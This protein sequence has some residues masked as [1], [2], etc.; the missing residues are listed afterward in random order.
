[1]LKHLNLII[2]LIVLYSTSLFASP[3]WFDEIP[4]QQGF[5]IGVGIGDNI[6]EAKQ[7]A[8]ADIGNTLYSNVSSS[9]AN[10]VSVQNENIKTEF[11]SNKLVSSENVLLPTVSWQKLEND[12]DIYYAMAKVSIAE[13]VS[14]Y[15]KNLTLKLSE[16]NNLL[17]EKKLSLAEYLQLVASDKTLQIAAQRAASITHLSEKAK[18]SFSQIMYL[19]NKKNQ[20]IGSVCFNVEKSHDRLADKIY[21]PAIE[22]AVQA[23]KFE[24]NNEASCIPIRFRSKTEK[25]RKEGKTI[26]DVT[27]Q[28]TI[29]SPS[30]TSNIIKFKGQSN[31]SYKSA[32]FDATDQFGNYFQTSGGLLNSLLQTSEKTI[33]IDS[34]E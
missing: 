10:K 9:I 15:E 28:L 21:L 23:D 2:Y 7:A 4:Q 18:V 20:F 6:A 13:L 3:K 14:L 32:M 26:A 16:F 33:V 19:F 12:D 22:S 25:L 29:G 24:L 11:L 30:M 8:M 31:R 34:L 1:M 17:N 27:M 5:F